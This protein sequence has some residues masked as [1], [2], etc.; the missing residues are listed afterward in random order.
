M[1]ARRRGIFIFE[2]ASLSRLGRDTYLLSVV[3]GEEGAITEATFC[4]CESYAHR[5]TCHHVQ[6]AE[7]L[8]GEADRAGGRVVRPRCPV[9]KRKTVYRKTA[10]GMV[11][12]NWKC[13]NYWKLGR[14]PTIA[15]AGKEERGRRG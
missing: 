11:C 8:A 3:Y 2:V 13:P 7:E 4:S 6:H 5:Q 10:R 14:G 9:C 1:V 15:L 12:K